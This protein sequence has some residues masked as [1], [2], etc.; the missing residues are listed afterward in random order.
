MTTPEFHIT[1]HG[2]EYG[3]NVV[4]EG[5]SRSSPQDAL[6]EAKQFKKYWAVFRSK[7]FIPESIFIEEVGKP[8]TKPDIIREK[9]KGKPA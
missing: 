6:D 2:K 3:K 5:I 8:A 7:V 9:T 1:I 4:F